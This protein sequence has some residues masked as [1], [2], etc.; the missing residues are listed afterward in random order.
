MFPS[1]HDG[2]SLMEGK[3]TGETERERGERKNLKFGKM[4]EGNGIRSGSGFKCP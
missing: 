3:E 1:V 2:K 4:K